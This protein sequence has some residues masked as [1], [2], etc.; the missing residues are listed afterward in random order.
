M[1]EK[2]EVIAI[3]DDIELSNYFEINGVISV[4]SNGNVI[5][6]YQGQGAH[7]SK[8]PDEGFRKMVAILVEVRGE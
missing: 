8:S 6:R 2:E 5:R 7:S 1:S 4:W 3:M